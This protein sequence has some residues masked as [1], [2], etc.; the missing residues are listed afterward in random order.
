MLEQM[1]QRNMDVL[2]R[3]DVAAIMRGWAEDGVLELAGHSSISGRYEGKA[4]IEAF[5]HQLFERMERLTIKV[6]RVALANPLGLNYSNTV[7]IVYDIEEVS[8]EG[9][10]IR[11]HNIAEFEYRRGK[12][13]SMREWWFDPTVLEPVWGSDNGMPETQ[14]DGGRGPARR[15]PAAAGHDPCRRDDP[16]QLGRARS[17]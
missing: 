9:V 3:K 11:S 6:R 8:R 14:P 15:C 4:A 10:S 13:V 5:F 12:V 7:F 17:R 1:A 2:A 16:G